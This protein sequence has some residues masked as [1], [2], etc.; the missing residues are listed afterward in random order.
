MAEQ[1][2]SQTPLIKAQMD[3]QMKMMELQQGAIPAQGEEVAPPPIPPT[4]L[5]SRIRELESGQLS[6][7]NTDGEEPVF[8]V[9]D[10]AGAGAAPAAY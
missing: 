3:Q 10:L 4:G 7:L 9:P 2:R 8:E 1:V 6:R 5:S